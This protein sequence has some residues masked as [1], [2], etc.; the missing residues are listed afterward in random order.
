MWGQK[1]T[2]EEPG[3]ADALSDRAIARPGAAAGGRECRG[4]GN[5]VAQVKRK[6]GPSLAGAAKSG[7]ERR[8]GGQTLLPGAEGR[9]RPVRAGLRG[10]GGGFPIPG[11]GPDPGAHPGPAGSPEEQVGADE[12]AQAAEGPLPA[13]RRRDAAAH[14]QPRLSQHRRRPGPA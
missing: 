5:A 14:G 13:Q 3:Q 7:R 8:A 1:P 2:V 6:A 4:A 10:P 9:R 11:G 12:A